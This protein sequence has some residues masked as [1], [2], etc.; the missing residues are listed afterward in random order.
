VV[1]SRTLKNTLYIRLEHRQHGCIDKMN[2]SICGGTVK[3]NV[4]E[5]VAEPCS[6]L[7]AVGG[8]VQLHKC[9]HKF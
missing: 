6:E 7:G 5:Q 8:G 9:W 4:G 1:A 3:Y 2:S